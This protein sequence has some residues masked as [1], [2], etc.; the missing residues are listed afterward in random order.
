MIV[1]D[2][3]V[4]IALAKMSSLELMKRAYREVLIGPIV[5]AETVDAGKRISAVGVE[6]IEQ[7][8]DDGW[9]KIARLS[10]K[11]K[12]VCRIILTRSRLDDGEAESIALASSRR[13]TVILDDK[14]ARS[15]AAAMRV[16]FFGT[17]GLLLD[18]FQRKLLT[19]NEIEDAVQQLSKTIW[20]PAQ[21]VAQILK[22]AR[23]E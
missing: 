6:H 12:K 17:A 18:A 21:V 3:T 7:A 5:K 9:L 10:A 15:F 1:A 14:E 2:A 19:S 22:I 13:L 23:E 20:L 4:L 16:D 8:I 11:E